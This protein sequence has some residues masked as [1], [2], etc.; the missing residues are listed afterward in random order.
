[1]TSL[2]GPTP[3]A[4]DETGPACLTVREHPT[5]PANTA[6]PLVGLRVLEVEGPIAGAYATMLLGDLG[7][8]VVRVKVVSDCCV[9]ANDRS[10]AFGEDWLVALGHH[11]RSIG[12]DVDQAEGREL[13]D[14]LV[15]WSDVV[16]ESVVPGR[17]GGLR[18]LVGTDGDRSSPTWCAI[19]DVLAPGVLDASERYPG[20]MT[21]LLY[22]AWSGF[23][24]LTGAP[25]G[26]P[27]R[28][29]LPLGELVTGIYAAIGIV[30]SRRPEPP[31][32]SASTVEVTRADAAVALLSYMAVSHFADGSVPQRLGSGHPT[33]FPYNA[34]RA[35]D[36]DLVVAPF[37][38][39]FWRNFCRGVGRED[40]VAN[41]D[42]KDFAQRLKHRELL[43]AELAPIFEERSVE[44]WTR[45]LEGADVPCGPVLDVAQAMLL[46]QTRSRGM[47][48]QR[49]TVN[50]ASERRLGSPFSFE[51]PD[52]TAFRPDVWRKP[53]GDPGDPE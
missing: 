36:G 21:D 16:V 51:Y 22:Q 52:G 40:L 1:M 9:T 48:C 26:A 45:V 38:Q 33:I 37:T 15:R 28:M 35:K 47:L 53:A 29:G 34:F 18:T 19:E 5:G 25:G 49:E 24:A 46:D 23:M 13:L 17:Q 7:A 20:D 43:F 10:V 30:A 6:S 12:V 14:Q 2:P 39:A 32:H 31:A 11:K 41:P 3:A 4:E 8:T 50:G 27:G 44:E 42:Y